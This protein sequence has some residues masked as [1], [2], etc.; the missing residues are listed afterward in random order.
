MTSS[1][2]LNALSPFDFHQRTRLVF[3]RGA[4]EQLGILARELSGK[5]VLVVTDSGLRKAGHCD[6]AIASL[7]AAGLTAIVFD[8][9]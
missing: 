1:D 5:R 6:R 2:N 7:T 8:Q 3:G 9:V 4:F